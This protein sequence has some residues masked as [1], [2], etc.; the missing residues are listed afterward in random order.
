M[1]GFMFCLVLY[2]FISLILL[3]SMHD[4]GYR[5]RLTR[6]GVEGGGVLTR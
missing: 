2:V 5:Y 1:R 6:H 3:G 4:E